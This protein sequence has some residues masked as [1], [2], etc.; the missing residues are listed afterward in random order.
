MPLKH[1]PVAPGGCVALVGN[2]SGPLPKRGAPLA[3]FGQSV[4]SVYLY[5]RVF[6]STYCGVRGYSVPIHTT[7]AGYNVLSDQTTG[8][9]AKLQVL[10][11]FLT[12]TFTFTFP[13]HDTSFLG[14]GFWGGGVP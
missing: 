9:R 8:P 1:R 11:L 6:I 14:F 12:L 2:H 10:Q 3:V 4:T 5:P 7:L 13:R